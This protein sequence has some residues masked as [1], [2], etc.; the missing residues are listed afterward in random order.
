MAD[1]LLADDPQTVQRLDSVACMLQWMR[2]MPARDRMRFLGALA[3]CSDAM[4]QVVTQML[5]VVKDPTT[6]QTERQCA[7]MAMTAAL[8]PD[9]DERG[10]YGLDLAASDSDAAA[11]NPSV[12]RL[13]QNMHT[14]E[15]TFAQCL[16][17]VMDAKR[18]SQQ[19]LAARV[20]VSQPAISQMLNRN[21]RPQKKTILRLAEA[22]K[23]QVCDLWPDIEVAELLDAVASFEQE[24]YVMTQAEA[25]ALGD[26]TQPNRPKI[27]AKSLPARRR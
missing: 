5:V 14:H 7:L 24:D 26:T 19:E 15:T 9:S 12:A 17:E 6:K 4:Q 16:R 8:F 13:V 18:V 1:T 23:V 2:T 25:L 11:E 3:D 22:L 27:Q 10:D 20:G 21:C